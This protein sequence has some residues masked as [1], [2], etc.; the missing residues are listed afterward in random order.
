MFLSPSVICIEYIK[1]IGDIQ[2]FSPHW[3]VFPP[4]C[5][6]SAFTDITARSYF[7]TLSNSFSA[8]PSH[9]SLLAHRFPSVS[10]SQSTCYSVQGGCRHYYSSSAYCCRT[11]PHPVS[12]CVMTRHFYLIVFLILLK[13][14]TLSLGLPTKTLNFQPTS[15]SACFSSW[16]SAL[17]HHIVFNYDII[18]TKW[19]KDRIANNLFLTVWEFSVL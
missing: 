1:C 13:R 8:S 10:P 4:V 5:N 2:T 19:I 3:L 18:H 15:L 14:F 6:S 7:R 16:N 17:F 11:I 9:N 12:F